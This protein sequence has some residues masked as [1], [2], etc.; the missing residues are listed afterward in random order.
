MR[1][2]HG[3]ALAALGAA[4]LAACGNQGSGGLTAKEN[5]GL[6]NAA[7]MLDEPDGIAVPDDMKLGDEGAVAVNAA[8]PENGTATD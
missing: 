3:F 7:A 5:E 2:L 6:N 1:G 4:L 8:V